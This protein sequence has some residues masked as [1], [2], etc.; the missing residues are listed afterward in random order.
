MLTINRLALLGSACLLAS[1]LMHCD[2]GGTNTPADLAS[3]DLLTPPDL[4]TFAPPVITTIAPATLTTMGGMLTITGTGFQSGAT[5]TVGGT[6]CSNPAVTPTSITC[7]APAKAMGCGTAPVVV[8]NPDMQST[9]NST[10]FAYRTNAVTYANAVNTM[11]TGANPRRVIAADVNNDMKP[12]LIT[13]NQGGNNV[14][15]FI[16]NGM[17]GFA[18]APTNLTTAGATTIADLAVGD[19][20]GDGKPDIVTANNGTGNITLYLGNNNGTFANGVNV[21]AGATPGAIT[22]A[23][24]NADMKLDVVVGSTGT[25]TVNV[26]LA[27]NM[28]TS[29]MTPT[30][31]T[32][33]GSTSIG[34]V[35]LADL[36]GDGKRDL[37]VTSRNQNN[38][39]VYQG[40]GGTTFA[41]PGTFATMGNNPFGLF[42]TDIN[43]DGKSDVVTANTAGNNVSVLIGNGNRTFAAAATFGTANGPESV[44]V[45]DMNNDGVMDI[46]TANPG[47]N[48]FSYLQGTG[49]NMYAGATNRTTG[50]G[51]ASLAVSDLNADGLR[52]VAVGHN[53]M[54]N[55]GVHLQQCQ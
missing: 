8:T 48:N 12:D 27:N 49:N 18:A 44:W 17:G 5:V 22:L 35:E 23:D 28:G 32:L 51:P 15:V 7:T 53:N 40:M 10:G 39:T 24:L 6:A 33:A 46:L 1:V 16:N 4:A 42:V 45:A 34:D 21:V 25:G 41:M 47:T 37:I 14:S 43:G 36:D 50:T 13:A 54:N 29:F 38:I 3:P 55:V 20:N 52:D 26:L 31:I 2:D 9:T 19:V 11:N 30:L